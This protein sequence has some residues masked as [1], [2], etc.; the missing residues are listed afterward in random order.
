MHDERFGW[1]NRPVDPYALGHPSLAVNP[2]TGHPAVA[3]SSAAQIR[4]VEWDGKK[5][6]CTNLYSPWGNPT[7]YPSLAFDPADGHPAIAFYEG[8]TGGMTLDWEA[9][10]LR[11]AWFNGET[12]QMQTVDYAGDV[13][14]CPSLAFNE[15]GNG[16]PAIAYFDI[17]G[18]LWY[19]EDPPVVPEPATLALLAAGAASV[20]AGR[21]RKTRP[22]SGQDMI[23]KEN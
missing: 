17:N 8:T 12:W 22:G 14:L 10:M 15:Y 5:W 23:E 13:G 21:R 3:Y 11:F 18:N 7:L 16:W 4:Y 1:V 20:L 19:I 6:D 9:Q 2:V